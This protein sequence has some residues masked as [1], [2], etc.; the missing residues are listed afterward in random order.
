MEQFEKPLRNLQAKEDEEYVKIALVEKE[1]ADAEMHSLSFVEYLN[2]RH[3]FDDLYD[4]DVEGKILEKIHKLNRNNEIE[5]KRSRIW[6][7]IEKPF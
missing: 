2:T 7:L 1:Q 3:L 5:Y 4:G 6:V